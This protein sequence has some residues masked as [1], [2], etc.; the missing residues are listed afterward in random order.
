MPFSRKLATA[1]IAALTFTGLSAPVASAVTSDTDGDKLLDVWETQGYDYNNDGII[2]IDFPALGANPYRKDLF[3]EMDYMPGLLAS[4]AELDTIV[5]TF[6]D[7]PIWNPD[8]STG[9]SLHLDAGSI[10]PAYD[11]GGGN[12]IPY[13]GFESLN[14]VRA[15]RGS[16]SDPARADLFHYMIW[17]DYYGTGGSSGSGQ[18]SGRVFMVTV[19]PTRW[20]RANSSTRIG[21]FIHELGHNL[22]LRH[23]GTDEVNYKP[24]YTSIMN[25]KYQLEGLRRTDGSIYYGYSTRAGMTLDET[26]LVESKGAGN[27]ARGFS[28][29]QNNRLWLAH[30][31]IDFDQDGQI[32]SLAQQVDINRDNTLSRLTAPNDLLTLRFQAVSSAPGVSP[33]EEQEPEDANNEL[34]ADLARQLGYLPAQ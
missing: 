20:S 34:T 9:I 26:N 10:Y 24:N 13:Q 28:I 1:A 16:N 5:Q 19:G 29:R 12:E 8:G 32:E 14:D 33:D 23:G 27:A 2:D 7:M 11:L 3:V 17:G 4:E 6:A 15:L 21:T 31:G 25:Y 30:G 18:V 22:G